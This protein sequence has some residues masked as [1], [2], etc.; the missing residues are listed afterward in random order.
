M[1][2]L[3]FDKFAVEEEGVFSSDYKIWNEKRTLVAEA[4]GKL[5]SSSKDVFFY[6]NK[7]IDHSNTYKIVKV[8]L[9]QPEYQIIKNNSVQAV[10][11]KQFS[12]LS[13]EFVIEFK[14]YSSMTLKGNMWKNDYVIFHEGSE[15]AKI[16]RRRLLFTQDVYGTAIRADYDYRLTLCII[17]ILDIIIDIER[18]KK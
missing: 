13:K 14:D 10:V 9:L 1:V 11:S 6:D 16:S 3:Q 15:I 17:I 4:K 12:L 5:F 8:G 7:V 2:E 18:K